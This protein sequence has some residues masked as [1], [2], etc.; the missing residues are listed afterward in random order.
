M[1]RISRPVL[2]NA[3]DTVEWLYFYYQITGVAYV[4]LLTAFPLQAHTAER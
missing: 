3:T 1:L 2:A 4:V